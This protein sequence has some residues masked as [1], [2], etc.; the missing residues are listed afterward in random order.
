[1]K[2]E[3]AIHEKTSLTTK[4]MLGLVCGVIAG[5][6]ISTMPE[7]NL[8]DYW[9]MGF[10][11]IV[12]GL[13][14]NSIKMLVV[15]LVF[16]SLVCG[17][18]SLG[19][20]NKLGRI[21][22]KTLGFYLLTTAIA[23]S[24]AL[25]LALL[26]QPGEDLKMT[27]LTKTVPKIL[28][29]QPFSKILQGIIPANP[30][31]AMAE[32]NMLQIIFFALLTGISITMAGTKSRPVADFFGSANAV[33]M[34]MVMLMMWLAPF[35]VFALIA[36]T[37]ATTGL[38]AMVPLL[39]YMIT[40]LAALLLHVCLIYLGA[41]KILGK[42]NPVQFIRNFLPAMS[43]A[44]STASSNGTL[45]VTI[46]TVEEKCGVSGGVAAFTLPLGAT[47]N[48]DGTAIMQGVAVVFIA[49]I[50][51]IDL[52]VGAL[53]TVILTATMASI[54]TAGVPGV[55][56]IT[57]S[58]VLESVNLP[59]EGIAL[60]IGVDR[61]LDMTR[62]VVNI[63]GDAVCTILVAKSEGEFDQQVFD[64]RPAGQESSEKTSAR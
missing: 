42:L 35:G 29:K 24:L 10:L 18:A 15:P 1:M 19:D 47:I 11:E 34:Q 64:A 27:E 6:A 58:M 52:P 45:P 48:M 30:V 57:L 28:P 31:A 61:L 50:Y 44:F 60:I 5:L 54:G 21:G 9:L 55:G 40:V 25:F 37:F 46:E 3:S 13:F 32:G 41:L 2:N 17:V 49:Q 53:L 23:I 39:K 8:R 26:V 43:V 14:I 36:Q 59:I 33:I 12:G 22:M 4:I 62:T 38:A 63:T 20:I 56:L 16:V 51:G 7:G